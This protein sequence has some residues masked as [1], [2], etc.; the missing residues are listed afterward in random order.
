MAGS[1]RLLFG[2]D[3]SSP[4]ASREETRGAKPSAESEVVNVLFTKMRLFPFQPW[5]GITPGRRVGMPIFGN[6]QDYVY[7]LQFKAQ[8]IICDGLQSEVISALSGGGVKWFRCRCSRLWNGRRKPFRQ[9]GCIYI[10][11][12]NGPI[13][14]KNE[15]KEVQHYKQSVCVQKEDKA[16]LFLEL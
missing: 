15:E 12:G 10:Y 7:Q 9:R 1:W 3:T 8:S 16:F 14:I 11:L 5:G 2:A 13:Y 4:A 6:L